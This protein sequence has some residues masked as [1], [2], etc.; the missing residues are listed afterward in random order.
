MGVV[1]ADKK[2]EKNVKLALICY[3]IFVFQLIEKTEEPVI[4]NTQM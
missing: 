4:F 1:I 3:C 2:K